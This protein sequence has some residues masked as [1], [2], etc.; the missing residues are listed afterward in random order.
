MAGVLRFW[1]DRG[2]DGFR[3]D[4]AHR[5][6][7]DPELDDN[8]PEV[9]LLRSDLTVHEAPMHNIDWPETHAVLREFRQ[10]LDE[11][12]AV[13]V[14]EVGILDLRRLVRYYGAGDELHMA[15][16]FKFWLQ[17]WSGPAF[18]RVVDEV[19]AAL[20]GAGW[21]VYALSN[22]DIPRAISRYGATDGRHEARARLAATM[23]FTLRGTP[24]VYYGEEIGMCD[25]TDAF[26]ADPNGRD[27]CRT[28]MQWEAGPGAGFTDGRPWLTIPESARWVNV[29]AQGGHPGS[30]LNLYRRL[31]WLRRRSTALQT[32]TY[33][34]VPAADECVFAYQRRSRDEDLLIAL[35]FGDYRARLRGGD[36]G[37]PA[38]GERLL[39]TQSDLAAEWVS[40]DPYDLQPLEGI[41]IRLSGRG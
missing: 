27:P 34:G 25:V 29:A 3:I 14:G 2:V 26:A 20:P 4:V 28:P 22:H 6:A 19:E 11:Y 41:V 40:L 15:F 32:G 18:R 33:R 5:L 36:I 38:A 24:F 7:K 30:L 37:L 8:P 13:A 16:N 21:P 10:I 31:I 1:L 12:G 39:S 9:A 17:P 35:N 23:F